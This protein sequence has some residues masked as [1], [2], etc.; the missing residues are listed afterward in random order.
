MLSICGADGGEE[1]LLAERGGVSADD[2]VGDVAEDVSADGL[3]GGGG[4]SGHEVDEFFE[5]GEDGLVG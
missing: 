1:G 2:D 4:G 5:G 3:G